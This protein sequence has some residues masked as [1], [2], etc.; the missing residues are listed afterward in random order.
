MIHISDAAINKAVQLM[1]NQGFNPNTHYLRLG[2]HEGCCQDYKYL[3]KFDDQKNESDV[4]FDHDS[5]KVVVDSDSLQVLQGTR[6]D[7]DASYEDDEDESGFF[8][9]NPMARKT[10]GCG[11]SFSA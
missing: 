5:V 9:E 3:F 10:C 6:I 11:S 4:V 2:V 7:F 1:N 8:F